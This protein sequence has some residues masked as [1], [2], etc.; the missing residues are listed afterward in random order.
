MSEK[1]THLVFAAH[2]LLRRVVT[3]TLRVIE[4]KAVVNRDT[5]FMGVKVARIKKTHIVGRHNRQTAF[6]GERTAACK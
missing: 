3:R 5:D 2:I 6:F 1:L 4:G